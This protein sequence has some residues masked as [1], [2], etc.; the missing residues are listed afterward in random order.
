MIIHKTIKVGRPADV[1]FKLF[2]DQLGSWWPTQSH[3]FIEG[4]NATSVLEP[5]VGGRLYEHNP[6][7]K[8]YTIG[9]VTAYEPG[10]L[11]AF[12]WNHGEGKGVTQVEVRFTA[13]GE[14]T[15]IDLKHSGWENMA[16]PK[17]AMGYDSGWDTV[18][19]YYLVAANE[20]K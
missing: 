8:E 5:R 17:Q 9:E 11:V 7:G 10:K 1:A 6:E 4:G 15:R 2:A 19:A 13:E 3:S 12:S 16:E 20:Q 14:G 18:L